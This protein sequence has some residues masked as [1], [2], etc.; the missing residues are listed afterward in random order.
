MYVHAW[1]SPLSPLSPALL[2]AVF[3]LFPHHT[4]SRSSFPEL[5]VC[6]YR[7]NVRDLSHPSGGPRFIHQCKSRKRQTPGPPNFPALGPSWTFFSPPASDPI[8]Y[9]TS[10]FR[11]SGGYSKKNPGK[12][13]GFAIFNDPVYTMDNVRNIP[14]ML[15]NSDQHTLQSLQNACTCLLLFHPHHTPGKGFSDGI[16]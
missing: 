8:L 11:E 13:H 14:V 7:L 3:S 4:S 5:W 6:L 16:L 12:G 15:T 2:E 9:F 10:Q 1:E